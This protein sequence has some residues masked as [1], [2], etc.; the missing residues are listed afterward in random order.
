MQKTDTR[1]SIVDFLIIVAM[2]LIVVGMFGQR[3]HRTAGKA[4]PSAAA[5]SVAEPSGR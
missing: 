5:T 4:K 2:L 3:L 1:F